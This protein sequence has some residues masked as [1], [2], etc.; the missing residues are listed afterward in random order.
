VFY[1]S[2]QKLLVGDNP[3]LKYGQDIVRNPPTALLF[4][5]PLALFTVQFSQSL[6]FTFSFIAFLVGSYYLF[7]II[8]LGSN[9]KINFVSL[10]FWELYLTLVFLFFPFRYNLGSG[11]I[12]N[13]LFL[14]L[15]L[16]FYYF[17]KKQSFKTGVFLALGIILKI[18]PLF[19][20]Y[21]LV[22]QRKFRILIYLITSL[23]LLLILPVLFFGIK[24]YNQF[25]SIG[26]SFVEFSNA[27]YY[28]QSF[29]GFL[30]RTFHSTQLTFWVTILTLFL[31]LLLIFKINSS[32]KKDFFS[33]TLIWNISILSML[34]FAPFAWQYHFVIA[35]FPLT[36]T[37][38]LAC[39]FKSSYLF[40]LLIFISYLGMG[41]NFKSPESLITL[42]VLGSV[43][44]SH[45]FWGSF[46]LLVL[47]YFLV[48]KMKP[49]EIN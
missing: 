32:S 2:G 40:Y 14:T 42:G 17:V 10:K 15:I 3:Y 23:A 29:T 49:G 47:N 19:F 18:T 31:S 5:V 20:F 4:F 16:S 48:F 44:L 34:I 30:S 35:I 45:T 1:L 6:W 28:N 46:L 9:N 8:S 27:T 24:I 37:S 13:F 7:K 38:Y 22:I 41:W 33:L 25:F 12:N 39:R 21:V 43:L 26:G 36:M 11:Q